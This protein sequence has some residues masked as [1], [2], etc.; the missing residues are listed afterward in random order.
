MCNRSDGSKELVRAFPPFSHDSLLEQLHELHAPPNIRILTDTVPLL[1]V[2]QRAMEIAA[3]FGMSS[4]HDAHL[5][6]L[7]ASHE[8][9]YVAAAHIV[10]SIL[11]S[12]K[13]NLHWPDE[14]P[15]V[16]DFLT[17]IE[18]NFQTPQSRGLTLSDIQLLNVCCVVFACDP[19]W[20]DISKYNF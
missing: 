20:A 16:T 8:H 4:P 10:A 17:R 15:H 12:R 6:R 2:Y 1:D 14:P 19:Q 11:M 3:V 5:R 9:N 7:V 18:K 13:I